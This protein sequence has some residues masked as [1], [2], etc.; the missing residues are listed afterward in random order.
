MGKT[1]LKYL[2]SGLLVLFF[3]TGCS[4]T[5]ID[6]YNDRMTDP[7]IE[8]SDEV[9]I[10]SY[11]L[12]GE[13]AVRTNVW[14]KA[15]V[16]F[17]ADN[18]HGEWVTITQD[19]GMGDFTFTLTA[20]A[21]ISGKPRTAT[22]HITSEDGEKV[23]RDIKITQTDDAFF[24][25]DSKEAT[26][27]ISVNQGQFFLSGS[28]DWE[29]EI[30]CEGGWLTAD[31]TGRP[32][33]NVPLTYSFASNT[34]GKDRTGVI[35]VRSVS[36]ETVAETFTVCQKGTMLT[37]VLTVTNN[38]LL[39]AVWT[40]EADDISVVSYTIEMRKPDGSLLKSIEGFT[41]TTLELASGAANTYPE[42]DEYIGPF[43]LT[44]IA[45]TTDPAI[46]TTSETVG[47][48][49]AFA[50]GSDLDT[51]EDTGLIACARH[52]QN[53]NRRL[54]GKYLQTENIDFRGNSF[55]AVGSANAPFTGTY[56]GGNM[57]IS[58]A[59][60][61]N[62][63]DKNLAGLFGKIS[64]SKA[65]VEHL[66]VERFTS[67]IKASGNGATAGLSCVV[68][69]N[70]GG[71]VSDVTATDCTFSLGVNTT[72]GYVVGNNDGGQIE[73]CRVVNT[74]GGGRI[75]V[76]AGGWIGGIAGYSQN[77]GIIRGC[78]VLGA[79]QLEARAAAGGIVGYIANSKIIN[80]H[81]SSPVAANIGS[82]GIVGRAEGV[83]EIT[84][85]GNSGTVSLVKV[86]SAGFIGGILGY[87]TD[88]A[89]GSII[90]KCYN[91]GDIAIENRNSKNYIGG[92]CGSLKNTALSDC[93]TR[94]NIYAISSG[95]KNAD[96]YCGGLCGLW[97]NKSNSASAQRCYCTMNFS[98]LINTKVTIGGIVGQKD[99]AATSLSNVFY[100]SGTALNAIGTGDATVGEGVSAQ[101]ESALKQASTY[102]SWTD[103]DIIWNF[104]AENGGFP[105]L[106]D[107]PEQT[108]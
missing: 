42:F 21:N 27:P 89:A 1:L 82:G 81:N 101:S 103:F 36:D 32:G 45:Q 65:R 64:G 78:R 56:D 68:G 86:N 80:C 58:N 63:T 19:E 26:V 2:T 24:E 4:D 84:G 50:T 79:E 23:I 90:S 60:L 71:V 5:E 49:T 104:P 88:T 66:K 77:G 98:K 47:M 59:E 33:I 40:P 91:T 31:E 48:H 93:Y 11:A 67:S 70:A 62:D 12:E 74:S 41:E 73:K 96:F 15:S 69:Y 37:P 46:F 3:T 87:S 29:T 22:L 55:T 16:L 14:W 85:C 34:T 51:Y 39:S 10:K 17:P 107:N 53:I 102:S 43:T 76:S 99:M 95:A 20:E 106:I 7:Y 75:S 54:N 18:P 105:G 52:F 92:L 94:G 25:L 108:L 38:D 83:I 9:K 13:I 44:V 35:T 28:S 72:F 100:L 61:R 57:T 30:D 97:D 6:L 8:A